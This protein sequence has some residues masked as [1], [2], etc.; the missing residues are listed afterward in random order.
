[1][2]DDVR[3]RLQARRVAIEAA[4]AR[5]ER[6]ARWGVCCACEGQIGAARLR[7]LPE[8]ELCVECQ[9]AAEEA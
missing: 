3:A 5:L 4:L 7:V 1:V 8:A 9:R 6:G 2:S